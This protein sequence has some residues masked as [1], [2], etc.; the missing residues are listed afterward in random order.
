MS[1]RR[2]M[3][4]DIQKVLERLETFDKACATFFKRAD[5]MCDDLH[6]VGLPRTSF[7]VKQAKLNF[8]L[9]LAYIQST[10]L[11]EWD[12]VAEATQ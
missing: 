7:L 3:N 6:T 2:N 9:T 1:E 5:K 10:A 4:E 12:N 8:L 11:D